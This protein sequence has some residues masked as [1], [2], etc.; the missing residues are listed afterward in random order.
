MRTRS[1]QAYLE[2]RLTKEEIAEI[3]AEVKK[4]VDDLCECPLCPPDHTFNAKTQKAI[5][6]AEKG[7]GLRYAKDADDLFKQL[8]I[9]VKK[10]KE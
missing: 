10:N 4:E 1:F 7:I 2:K 9:K 3:E 6:D 5:E 8:G